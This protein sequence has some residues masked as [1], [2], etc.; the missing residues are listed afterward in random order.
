M[1]VRRICYVIAIL[2]LWVAFKDLQ[3]PAHSTLWKNIE[4]QE[5][6][7]RALKSVPNSTIKN[8]KSD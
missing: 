5:V 7:Q 3:R 2:A 6:K 1:I 8:E 4:K